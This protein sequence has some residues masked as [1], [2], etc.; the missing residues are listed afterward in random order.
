MGSATPLIWSAVIP[1]KVLALAKSRLAG[2][3]D[4][5]REALARA[6]GADTVSAAVGSTAIAAVTVVSDD[7]DVKAVAEAAGAGV[8]ADLPGA[9][10]NQALMAGARHAAARW[11]DRGLAALTADLPAL[12][13]D[14]L[15]AAPAL[16]A[17]FDQAFVAAAAGSGTTL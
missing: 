14:E 4:A 13:A 3:A 8:I 5:D 10:L 16:P 2:L 9:D 15:T 12:C 6:M 11:P 7:P 1:V 17:G